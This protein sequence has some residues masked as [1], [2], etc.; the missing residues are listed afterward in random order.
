MYKEKWIQ[1]WDL[2]YKKGYSMATDKVTADQIIKNNINYS[3]TIFG[4]PILKHIYI[5]IGDQ[6][7]TLIHCL[8]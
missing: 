8:K 1:R 5:L 4:I 7:K 6:L 2:N 3:R